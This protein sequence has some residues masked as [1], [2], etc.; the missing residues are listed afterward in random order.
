MNAYLLLSIAIVA[1]VIG[2]SMLKK[3]E[4]FKKTLPSLAVI[5]GYAIAFYTLSLSLKTLPLGLAYAIW[6]GVGTALTALVGIVY[7]KE[8]INIKKATGI[9]LIIGGVVLLNS[10]I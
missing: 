2:S 6:A 7:Y 3:T 1:E 5:V 9:L 8:N 4:G 10:G